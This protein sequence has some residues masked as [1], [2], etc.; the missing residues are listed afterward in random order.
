MFVREVSEFDLSVYGCDNR[1]SIPGLTR[2]V[3][4]IKTLRSGKDSFI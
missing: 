1:I 4:S 2:N 3:D